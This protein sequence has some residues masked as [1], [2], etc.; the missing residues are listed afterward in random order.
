MSKTGFPETGHTER[1]VGGANATLRTLSN[2]TWVWKADA[3]KGQCQQ[4]ELG[5]HAHSEKS[6]MDTLSRMDTGTSHSL[7][8]PSFGHLS[9]TSMCYQTRK[10]LSSELDVRVNYSGDDL[11]IYD[12]VFLLM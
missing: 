6:P 5:T 4:K 9:V 2:A 1:M 12:V 10:T 11:A 7:T 8:S 3:L